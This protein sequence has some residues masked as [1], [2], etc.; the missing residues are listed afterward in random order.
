MEVTPAQ[1]HG[2]RL[3]DDALAG[4]A[5][6]HA[7]VLPARDRERRHEAANIAAA[8]P[9]RLEYCIGSM[10]WI[11]AASSCA[12]RPHAVPRG[13]RS[14]SGHAPQPNRRPPHCG[15]SSRRYDRVV[16]RTTPKDVRT[17]RADG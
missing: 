15:P 5:R 7:T 2:E 8:P 1:A 3:G 12:L 6:D 11:I 4:R 10:M 9:G 14:R 16:S 13:T 17:P